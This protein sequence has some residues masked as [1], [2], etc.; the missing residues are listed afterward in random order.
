MSDV[1]SAAK[2]SREP[3]VETAVVKS[4]GQEAADEIKKRLPGFKPSVAIVLG[5][6]LGSLA[7]SIENKTCIKYQDLPGFPVSTVHG[8]AGELVLG[9]LKGTAV[10]CLSGRIHL[11]EGVA[12]NKL[13][14]PIYTLALLGCK[15]LLLTSAT[16]SLRQEV[17][18]GQL[19]V[20][21]DHINMT[22]INPLVGLN[23][24]IGTRFPST[25]NL[26]DAD[27]RKKAHDV[28]KA[29][30]VTLHDGVYGF[31]M[32]PSFETPAEIRAYRTLGADVV[33]M[34]VVGEALLA[35]HSGMKVLAFS[36]VVNL[37]SGMTGD[38]ITHEDTLKYSQLCASNLLKL[39][40]GVLQA[41]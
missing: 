41:L 9:M 10:V 38:D 8:H 34:S 35:R 36:S 20:I 30:G 25:V 1:E 16:G 18:P 29:A 40:M 17:G 31:A 3:E 37:A 23:D 28:A 14:V 19:V 32:G 22:G 7:D 13:R 39:V 11:Y 24:P 15:M 4:V 2:R 26:Y 27:L 6:G 12:P 5:S 33:G 21:S